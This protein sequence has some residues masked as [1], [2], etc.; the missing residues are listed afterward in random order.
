MNQRTLERSIFLYI[1]DASEN[2]QNLLFKVLLVIIKQNPSIRKKNI[3]VE[4]REKEPLLTEFSVSRQNQS[5]HS[6]ICG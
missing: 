4:R 3:L 6:E 5:Q 1:Q 2:S